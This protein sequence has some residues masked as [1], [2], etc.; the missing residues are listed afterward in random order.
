MPHSWEDWLFVSLI[1]AFGIV[2]FFGITLLP[3]RSFRLLRHNAVLLRTSRTGIATYAL[4]G[5]AAVTSVLMASNSL[6][7]ISK[8][9][10]GFHCNANRSG[11][12]LFLASIG[13]WYLAFELVSALILAVARRSKGVAT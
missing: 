13:F 6:F 2:G 9:L 8:C 5:A 11:G 12:W 3:W 7:H 4:L 1:Y 10:L